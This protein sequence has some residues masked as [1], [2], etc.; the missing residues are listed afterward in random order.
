M[1]AILTHYVGPSNVRGSRYI[2][3]NADGARAIVS[4]D[5]SLDSF[6]NHWRAAQALCNKL[7]WHGICEAGA[8][9]R[10]YAFVFVSNPSHAVLTV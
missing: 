9:K 1:Q 8:T 3:T 2:A 7:G 6:E 5:H 4:A 10:G